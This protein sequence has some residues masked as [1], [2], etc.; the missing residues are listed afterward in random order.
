MN[1]S[2]ADS[3]E[4]E[5]REMQPGAIVG[6]RQRVDRTM[7]TS[8]TPTIANRQPS[9]LETPQTIESIGR[10]HVLIANKLMLSVPRPIGFDVPPSGGE[11]GGAKSK[12]PPSEFVAIKRKPNRLFSMSYA[13]IL[14]S[15][16]SD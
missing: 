7:V 1:A 3:V 9:L 11:G 10:V 6:H 2:C 13:V 5:E 16:C 12:S 15:P 8:A 14:I 4:I